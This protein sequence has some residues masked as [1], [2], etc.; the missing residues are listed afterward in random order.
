MGSSGDYCSFSKAVEHLGDRWSLVIVRDLLLHGSLGFNALADGMPGISRSVLAAR[1][2]KLEDLEVIVRG[3][4]GRRRR[5][6]YV[7][8]R[9]G[10]ELEPIV[11]ALWQWSERFVPQDPAMA[12]RDPDIVVMWLSQRIEPAVF[13]EQPIVIQLDVAGALARRL[14]LVLERGLEPSPCLEDP[15]LAA[16]RYVYVEADV[17]ALYPIARGNADFE[18]ALADRT[19]HVY[20]PPALVRAF[21]S[22]FRPIERPPAA[23]AVR[24]IRHAAA[25]VTN[26]PGKWRVP[27]SV[28]PFAGRQVRGGV[29]RAS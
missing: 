7:L 20:G 21:P 23:A 5:P 19:V 9:A 13:P 18:R 16:D 27:P 15:C 11:R 6:V 25:D 12:E 17:S 3:A 14:W 8:T 10:R 24:E 26:E 1:L 28:S 22:W 4:D 29:A 2:R